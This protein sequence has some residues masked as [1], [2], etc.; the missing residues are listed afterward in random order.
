MINSNNME[1]TDLLRRVHN[2]DAKALETLVPLIYDELKI[3]ASKH[4]QREYSPEAIQ[5]TVLVHEAF[6]RLAGTP[7]P[8]CQ[9]RSHFFS[10]AYEARSYTTASARDVQIGCYVDK[11]N[12]APGKIRTYGLLLRRQTLYPD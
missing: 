1:I 6:L 11:K 9:N 4:L 7:L 8:E 2:G 3:L 5:T 12:G 10:I